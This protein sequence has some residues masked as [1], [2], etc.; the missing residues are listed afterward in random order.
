[1]SIYNDLQTIEFAHGGNILLPRDERKTYPVLYLFHGIGGFNEWV[2]QAN[3][4]KKMEKLVESGEA[5]A[6]IVVM[7]KIPGCRSI[8]NDTDVELQMLQGAWDQ[9]FNYDIGG[10]VNYINKKYSSLIEVTENS[11]AIAGYS[12][13]A[14]AAIYHAVNNRNL[15]YNLGAVSVST[16]TQG[17]IHKNDFVFHQT[18]DSVLYIGYGSA[19]GSD[20]ISSDQYCIN[21]FKS[22]GYNNITE[23]VKRG[24]GHSFATF[25]ELLDEFISKIFKK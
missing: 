19:E 14:T 3:I 15:F 2:S 17:Y 16:L 24:T 8:D 10:L 13:G 23:R 4:V 25:N 22:N 11:T 1:M 12:M 6:S 18:E 21:S 5:T 9:F 20:F 7:P